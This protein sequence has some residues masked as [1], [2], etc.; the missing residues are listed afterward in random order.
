MKLLN[1]SRQFED[2]LKRDLKEFLSDAKVR[3]LINITDFDT[4]Y[5]NLIFR[6]YARFVGF[7]TDKLLELDINPLEYFKNS[8]PHSF[9]YE[10]QGYTDIVIP[11]NISFIESE[12]FDD[13]KVSSIVFPENLLTISSRAFHGCEN[14]SH[15]DFSKCNKLSVISDYAFS[16][17]NIKNLDLSNTIV[18][19]ISDWSFYNCYKLES[20]KLSSNTKYLNKC[21]FGNCTKLSEIE[22]HE[23]I[24]IIDDNAFMNTNLKQIKL[25]VS[26][27]YIGNDVFPNYLEELEIP[28]NSWMKNI[29][30]HLVRNCTNLKVLKIPKRFED[31]VDLPNQTCQVI[32]T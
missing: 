7:L 5:K 30:P 25:P 2:I 21:C 29:S 12:A 18:E 1:E 3:D 10:G 23:G 15:I 17:S 8:I 31:K 32:Y 13:S 19:T 28:S 14:L 26:C 22:L 27:T 16:L 9:S 4:L 20:V 6:K 11:S 24:L